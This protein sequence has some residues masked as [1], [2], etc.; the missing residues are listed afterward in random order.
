MVDALNP[1]ARLHTV[2]ARAAQA[3]NPDKSLTIRGALA[4]GLGVENEPNS[5]F[6]MRFGLLHDLPR[7]IREQVDLSTEDESERDLLKRHLNTFDKALSLPLNQKW[8]QQFWPSVDGAPMQSLEFCSVKLEAAGFALKLSNDEYEGLHEEI[9]RL[10]AAV[11]SAEID[12]SLRLILARHAQAMR[13]A[14]EEVYLRGPDAIR[15]SAEAM[16]GAVSFWTEGREMPDDGP[17][18][19]LIDRAVEVSKKWIIITTAAAQTLALPIGVKGALD[20]G[21]QPASGSVVNVEVETSNYYRSNPDDEVVDAEVV[22][23]G[24]DAEPENVDEN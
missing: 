23:D 19:S 12:D 24:D 15:Y 11:M 7:Q 20:A 13:S 4:S 17:A 8:I 2:L 9:A 3:K 18:R 1:A 22:E 10:L 6:Y 5:L 16:Q 21:P 14:L